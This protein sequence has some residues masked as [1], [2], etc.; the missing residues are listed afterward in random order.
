M[1]GVVFQDVKFTYVVGHGKIRLDLEEIAKYGVPDGCDLVHAGALPVAYGTSHV[2]LVHRA[3]HK[4]GQ[5]EGLLKKPMSKFYV[6]CGIRVCAT[7]L[8]RKYGAE[9][10]GITISPVPADRAHALAAAQGLSNKSDDDECETVNGIK[11]VEDNLAD[12]KDDK[13]R[14]EFQKFDKGIRQCEGTM[15]EFYDG[16][17]QSIRV[18]HPIVSVVGNFVVAAFSKACKKVWHA[19]DNFTVVALWPVSVWSS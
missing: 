13:I 11:T 10:S 1:K 9:C 6:G 8:S 16:E 14:L 18:D 2:A 12:A 17:R 15:P 19:I 5:V 7:H 4:A 3:N